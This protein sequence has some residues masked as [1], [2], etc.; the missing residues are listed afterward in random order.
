MTYEKWN[1]EIEAL[2]T[3]AKRTLSAND[4]ELG[5]L[6]SVS[7]SLLRNRSHTKQ[8]PELKLWVVAQ[9]AKAAGKK[10]VLVDE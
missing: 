9:M 10:L 8:M 6:L 7:G 5:E 3:A 4:N 2:R 1:G